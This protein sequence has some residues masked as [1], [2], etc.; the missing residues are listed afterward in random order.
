LKNQWRL[1][2]AMIGPFGERYIMAVSLDDYTAQEI[3]RVDPPSSAPFIGA[4]FDEAVKILKRRE[5]RKDLFQEE[6][7]RLSALLAERMEDAEGWH[8]IG[9]QE[10][11]KKALRGERP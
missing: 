6:A 8:D 11:A 10:P 4:T 9:R 5:F 2:M 3:H 7:R 1:E